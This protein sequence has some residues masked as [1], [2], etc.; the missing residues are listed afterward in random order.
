M[1]SKGRRTCSNPRAQ[2]PDRTGVQIRKKG[3]AIQK[4][5]KVDQNTEVLNSYETPGQASTGPAVGNHEKRWCM[6][7]DNGVQPQR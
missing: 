7:W 3:T 5:G 6:N 2:E 1:R 4:L